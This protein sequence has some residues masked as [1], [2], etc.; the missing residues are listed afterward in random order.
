MP[1][2]PFGNA[3]VIMECIHFLPKEVPYMKLCSSCGAQQNDDRLTCLDCGKP[4]GASLSTDQEAL[5]E[6]ET[7]IALEKQSRRGDPPAAGWEK[8]VGV[9]SLVGMVGCF[10]HIDPAD[11]LLSLLIA[12]VLFFISAL[13]ALLPKLMWA[14]DRFQARQTLESD[15]DVGPS[16]TYVVM[17]LVM[18]YGGPAV[19]VVLLIARQLG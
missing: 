17:R 10:L 2:L 16:D 19:A 14:L 9:L 5:V 3:C 15:D 11:H 12:I 13:Y 4:L 7:Q 1:G 18:I 8:L 6:R